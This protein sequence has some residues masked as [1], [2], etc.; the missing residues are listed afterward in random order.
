M[1]PISLEKFVKMYC[2]NNP[3]ENPVRLTESLKQAVLDKKNGATCSNCGD[4]IWA[5]GSAIA[6][7]SCFSCLTGQRDSS[8]DYEIN[9]VCWP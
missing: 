2:E 4:S 8:T 3:D 9:E 6:Y 1:V 5:I 7:Q